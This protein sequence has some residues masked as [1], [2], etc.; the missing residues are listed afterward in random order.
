MARQVSMDMLELPFSETKRRMSQGNP[1]LSFVSSNLSEFETRTTKDI[2]NEEIIR[3]T[4]MLSMFMR[5]NDTTGLTIQTFVFAMS[6][7]PEVQKKT[8]E[9]DNIL[10][11]QRLPEVA[12]ILYHTGA[13]SSVL[14][15]VVTLLSDY[16][17]KHLIRSSDGSGAVV[18]KLVHLRRICENSTGPMTGSEFEL[19]V[20]KVLQTGGTAGSVI[21]NRLTEE[22]RFTVL[23]IEAGPNNKGVL[24]IEVPAFS[25]RL[26][27]SPYD[28][29]FTTVPQVGLNGRSLP[30]TRGHVLGGSSSINGMVFTRGSS[31]DYDRWAKLLGIMVGPGMHF[32]EHW[33]PPVDAHNTTGEFDP[34]AHGFNG[35]NYV[36]LGSYLGSI[37]DRVIQTTVDLK[38][39]FPYNLDMND[40]N[41]LGVGPRTRFTAANEVI[42][43]AGSI[44]TP[45]I[46]LNSGIDVGKNLSDQPV[47]SAAWSTNDPDPGLQV[48]QH[49]A[50]ILDEVF[51]QWN[52]TRTG[53]LVVQ[54]PR[55][56]TAWWRVPTNTPGFKDSSAGPKSPHIEIALGYLG[57]S[58]TLKS[59]NP[60]D[61]PLIDVAYLTN[62]NDV[63][64][65]REGIKATKRF[66][67]GPV[68]KDLIIGE[69]LPG[70]NVTKDDELTEYIHNGVGTTLH[71]VGTAAMSARGASYGVVDPDL[72]VKGIS[73]LR[74]VDASIM[75]F[76]ISGHT[77]AGV[78]LIA[79]RGA[80]LIKFAWV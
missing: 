19:D 7:Y 4:A 11:F 1:K 27:N 75:P 51:K 2:N 47:T 30:Y 18:D 54:F 57:G 6:L 66:F 31:D 63:F 72:R 26:T 38:N 62:E 12:D 36:S 44:A 79:E 56:E 20:E 23:P 17:S 60:F 13:F 32:N 70:A 46:L 14:I 71:A 40:G 77:Q 78:Y 29:N 41:F 68:W 33:V 64:A 25:G 74:I 15:Q 3:N 8:Q 61:A 50:T 65:L 45:Q 42:L 48:W 35:V 53:P 24:D 73:G 5:G 9:I 43:S 52:A 39:E 67:G 16:T 69:T 28:W 37:D 22:P 49:N 21:A 58:V 10:G 80:D 76:V 55:Q 59:N 34:G